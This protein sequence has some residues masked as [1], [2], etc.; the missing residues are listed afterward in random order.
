VI[1]LFAQKGRRLIIK[2]IS[3]H[4]ENW[5]GEGMGEGMEARL[6]GVGPD[7][8]NEREVTQQAKH[9]REMKTV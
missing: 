1:K 8:P 9:F 6:R 3:E 5:G 7:T 2:K 4:T